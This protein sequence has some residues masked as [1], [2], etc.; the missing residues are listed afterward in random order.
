[1]LIS[2]SS[3]Y[4]W[5]DNMIEVPNKMIINDIFTP[6]IVSLNIH[7]TDVLIKE[8]LTDSPLLVIN[9]GNLLSKTDLTPSQEKLIISF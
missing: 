8:A 9:Y 7:V 3:Q 6:F 1:M 2:S 5:I 4:A